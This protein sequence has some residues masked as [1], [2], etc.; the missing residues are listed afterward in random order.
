MMVFKDKCHH[1]TQTHISE[2]EADV[3]AGVLTLKNGI[4]EDTTGRSAEEMWA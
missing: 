3:Y 4:S 2:G 1:A